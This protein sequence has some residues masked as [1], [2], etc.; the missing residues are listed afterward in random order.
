MNLI[1]FRAFLL[2]STVGLAFQSCEKLIDPSFQQSGYP[3]EI[4]KILV[5]KCA[6]SGC[7]NNSSYQN[8]GNLNLTT[9]SKLFE[10]AI[11]GAVVVPFSPNQ[12]SL[13]QFIN[14]YDDI[15]LKASPT[16]PLNANALSRE[17]VLK[18]KNWINQGSPDIN[19]LV[20]FSTNAASRSKM[21]IT[22]QGCDIVSVVDAETQLVMRYVKV[23]KQDNI[24]ELPHNIRVS[25]DKKYWFV[26]FTN[27]TII[28]KFDAVTDTLMEE[29]EIGAGLW[30]IVKISSDTKTALVSDLS[31]NGKIVEINLASKSMKTYTNGLFVFPHGMAFTKS[32]DTIYIVAQY[33]NMM[34][35]LIPSIS[36]YKVITLQNGHAPVTTAGILDPHEIMA[37][38]DFSHYF[39]TCQA[40]NE[41]RV[42]QAGIDTV[43]KIIPVGVYPLEMAI[44]KSKNLLFVTCQED[45]NPNLKA[46][47]SVYVID[48]KTLNVVKII[49]EKFYQPHGIAFDDKKNYLYVISRNA[50]PNGPAPHHISECGSRNGFFHVIDINTWQTV[51]SGSEISVDPYSAD[52][53]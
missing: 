20:P 39:I 19:G 13:M 31:N 42:L 4:E 7:H 6:T 24:T 53:R 43:V 11:N 33:G 12:S 29:F 2:I 18:I 10:G 1:K 9:Y 35:R 26:C 14:T 41:V 47:G 36:G 48:M 49:K 5:D 45:A 25:E 16:M 17:E 46:K 32:N 40:S 51:I 37:S 38:P 27:G 34:Y 50:D 3:L 52:F 44:S 22:N 21:Y 23:G 30:N 8:A 15:G 28:Q